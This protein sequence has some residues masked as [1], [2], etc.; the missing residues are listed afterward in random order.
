MT[1]QEIFNNHLK[2]IRLI[3]NVLDNRSLGDTIVKLMFDFSDDLKENSLILED[4][5]N[6]KEG[7]NYNR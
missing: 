2:K 1:Y 4:K 5:D 3:T 7:K 6:D